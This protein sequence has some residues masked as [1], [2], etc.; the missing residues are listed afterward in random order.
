MPIFR[1][2]IR[3]N[4]AAAKLTEQKTS[5]KPSALPGLFSADSFLAIQPFA[6]SHSGDNSRIGF[7]A[8]TFSRVDRSPTH[9][10][11]YSRV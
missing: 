2:E 5:D 6:T 3:S 10:L 1:G 8:P 9:F 4:L 7:F 11:F